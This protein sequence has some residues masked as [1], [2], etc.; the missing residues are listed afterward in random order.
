M[1]RYEPPRLPMAYMVSL[2]T[3]LLFFAM[4]LYSNPNLP[5]SD[6]PVFMTLREEVRR[7]GDHQCAPDLTLYPSLVIISPTI[8]WRALPSYT[9][10][11]MPYLARYGA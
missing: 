7:S 6:A 11:C 9:A 8:A 5:P 10:H 3:V 4:L 1:L 2:S